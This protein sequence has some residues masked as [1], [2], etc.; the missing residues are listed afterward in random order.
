MTAGW[1]AAASSDGL[2]TPFDPEA[3]AWSAAEEGPTGPPISASHWWTE[4]LPVEPTETEGDS[5]ETGETEEDRERGDAASLPS[6]FSPLA[7]RA[8][9]LW[10]ARD[11]PKRWQGRVYGLVVH[12]TGGGLPCAAHTAGRYHTVQAVGYY[13]RT[14]GTHY[15]N[16]WKGAAGG[17]LLQVA[18]EREQ[19]KGVGISNPNP[20]A[21]QSRSIDLDR[22]E[23][24][25]PPDLVRRWRARWPGYPH[26][27]ALLPESQPSGR[28]SAN[29]CYVHVEC[30]PCVYSCAGKHVSAD[31]PLRPGLRFTRAQHDTVALLACDI[32]TRNG[33][34]ASERWWRSPRLLG[35][36]DLTPLT[37]HDKHGGW[38]P[39]YL[40]KQPY[41]DWEYVYQAIERIQRGAPVPGRES[42]SGSY[43]E[44]EESEESFT[45]LYEEQMAEPLEETVGYS[46]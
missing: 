24:D 2:L 18:N 34:P 20:A 26:S 33:W 4:S 28:R 19:A 43:E 36:E 13:T 27:L 10:D 1:S 16:G 35:H 9:K 42:L 25:L 5:E 46:R 29:A 15:V 31:E 32:A 45:D 40:R 17:D 21:D 30:V 14:H 44:P 7:I 39:G 23:A 3:P 22:F 37:R 6:G 38:D 41:F 12:T 11:R 8:A